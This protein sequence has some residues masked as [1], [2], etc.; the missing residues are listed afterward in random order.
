VANG[1]QS[2]RRHY[3][4]NCLLDESNISPAPVRLVHFANVR[5]VTRFSDELLGLIWKPSID[6]LRF[7]H[8]DFV[9]TK[10]SNRKITAMIVIE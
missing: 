9:E 2:R 5:K 7:L 6:F 3:R 8:I 4:A 1:R 10:H